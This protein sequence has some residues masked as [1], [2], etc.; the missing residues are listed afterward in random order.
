VLL[1]AFL[2]RRDSEAFAALVRRHGPLVLGVCRRVLRHEQDAEDAFQATFLILSRQ[3]HTL[4][5]PEALAAWLHDVARHTALRARASAACRRQRE[6]GAAL[7]P[8]T[9]LLDELSARELLAVVDEELA[10]LPEAYRLPL[11]LCCLQGLSQEQAARRLG[12]TPGS[13]KGRLERGRARLQRRLRQR[14][15]ALSAALTAW[16]VA[17]A[18]AAVPAALLAST[19]VGAVT[20]SVPPSVA[21][22]ARTAWSCVVVRRL[23]LAALLLAVGLCGTGVALLGRTEPPAP[24]ADPPGEQIPAAPAGPP[25]PRV[26][27]FGDPLPEGALARLGTV[28]FRQGGGYVNA[29]LLTPDGKTLISNSYFGE[30]TV[31]AWELATGKLLRRFPGHYEEIRAVALSPD[32]RTLATGHNKLIRF[33]DLASGRE[34][35]R[36]TSPL[37]ET[38]GLA[39]TPDGKQLASGHEAH[40]VLLWDL[41]AR[42]VLA[43][44]PA[45]HNR[46]S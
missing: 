11:L 34:T 8:A 27:R 7:P 39:F 22:L 36:L 20:G 17:D 5:R 3:A 9:D 46:L 24:S 32:G 35:G 15:L 26:D 23:H 4:R 18:T 19:A 42:K 21:A 1:Q 16:L 30:R 45:Q 43:R 28:R 37:G 33:W 44:L 40:T 12:W 10:R 41:G 13:V 6:Q 29:L 25:T 38:Q 14:G 2:T 31:C